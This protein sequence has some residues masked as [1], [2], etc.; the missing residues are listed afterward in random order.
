MLIRGD[1]VVAATFDCVGVL[2]FRGRNDNGGCKKLADGRWWK[3][4][5]STIEKNETIVVDEELLMT[6]VSVSEENEKV[7]NSGVSASGRS[8][9]C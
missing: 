4:G 7:L 3:T 2:L 8:Q 6:G 1:V 9:S 5:V